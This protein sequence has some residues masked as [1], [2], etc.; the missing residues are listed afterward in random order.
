MAAAF[1]SGKSLEQEARSLQDNNANSSEENEESEVSGGTGSGE[2]GDEKSGKHNKDLQ[3]KAKDGNY[4]SDAKF[5][6]LGPIE[7]VIEEIRRF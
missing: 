5:S 2:Q 3:E 4:G 7:N 6:Q 1:A